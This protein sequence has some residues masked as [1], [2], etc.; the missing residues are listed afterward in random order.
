MNDLGEK[1]DFGLTRNQAGHSTF[2]PETEEAK[3]RL[4]ANSDVRELVCAT[5]ATVSLPQSAHPGH[6]DHTT[7]PSKGPGPRL[8]P[9]S[10]WA[11]I[12]GRL[13]VKRND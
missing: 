10:L 12:R 1:V 11:R 4:V 5:D 7:S 9:M 3:G 8:M 13:G 6:P 2:A